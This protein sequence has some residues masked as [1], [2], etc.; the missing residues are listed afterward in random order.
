M[1]AV[2][3]DPSRAH[4]AGWSPRFPQLS[5]GLVG[6][7]EEWSTAEIEQ[8]VARR[9]EPSMTLAG[10]EPMVAAPEYDAARG[11][12]ARRRARRSWPPHPPGAGAPLAIVIPA[13]NE[14]PTVAEVI[15]G[16]PAEVGRAA[17]RGDRRRRRRQGRD[18]RAG[19]R[20][21]RARLRRPGQP[22]PGRGAAA[23]LLAGPRPRRQ[24]DRDDRRRRPVRGARDR[25]G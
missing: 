20:G 21:R 7:W 3:V 1:P 24:G 9:R 5:D 16:I 18:R 6:V 13:Y 15:A 2:I 12:R 19:A 25:R 4:A 11:G 10:S 8:P 22:R 23:R 17:D 14:E